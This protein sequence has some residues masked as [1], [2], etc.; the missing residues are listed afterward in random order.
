MVIQIQGT[1]SFG[2]VQMFRNRHTGQDPSCKRL[3]RIDNPMDRHQEW[4]STSR[5]IEVDEP[6]L[7]GNL[8]EDISI[9]DI[10]A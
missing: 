4:L 2:N 5:S 1:T 6:L 8:D 10:V 3:H 7:T 9:L